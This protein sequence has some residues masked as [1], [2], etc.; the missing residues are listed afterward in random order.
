MAIIL[1]H[2]LNH[3]LPDFLECR[4]KHGSFKS[5]P[6]DGFVAVVGVVSH[7]LVGVEVAAVANNDSL[8]VR[9]VTVVLETRSRNF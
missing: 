7:A 6:D 2:I 4:R 8:V 1:K 9:G 5:L 3:K